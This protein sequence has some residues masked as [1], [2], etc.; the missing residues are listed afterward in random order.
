M[1]K[2][3][4]IDSYKLTIAYIHIILLNNFALLL[5]NFEMVE[6]P[7]FNILVVTTELDKEYP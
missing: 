6:S 5:R 2:T 4:N 3:S 1:F 7:K